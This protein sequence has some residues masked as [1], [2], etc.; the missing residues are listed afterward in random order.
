MMQ[1]VQPDGTI[2][3]FTAAIFPSN[4]SGQK[5]QRQQRNLMPKFGAV[6]APLWR[7]LFTTLDWIV[8]ASSPIIPVGSVTVQ[9]TW[10]WL[11]DCAE[12]SAQLFGAERIYVVERFAQ[13]WAILIIKNRIPYVLSP[14]AAETMLVEGEV[15]TTS[16]K[17]EQFQVPAN[18]NDNLVVDVTTLE[19]QHSEDIAAKE[20][21]EIGEQTYGWLYPTV[22]GIRPPSV[23]PF[24]E[25]FGFSLLVQNGDPFWYRPD[26]G[27]RSQL[28]MS[29]A[30]IPDTD[31]LN[32][33]REIAPQGLTVVSERL[34]ILHNPGGSYRAIGLLNDN[35]GRSA[36]PA[37][38][39]V[40]PVS[41]EI[42]ANELKH[43]LTG[44]L[45]EPEIMLRLSQARF[46]R[47][48]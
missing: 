5:F 11:D 34:L 13:I 2:R 16:I 23:N 38:V 30:Q 3:H 14:K 32:Y 17:I 7:R 26:L 31:A 19:I 15:H 25:A 12:S 24:A 41:Y 8:P 43:W 37:V 33:M 35:G 6:P 27:P 1:S 44:R 22:V 45:S 39:D 20:A 42:P 18:Y 40:V 9:A 4:Q 28:T 21:Q 46:A 10:D 47:A 48:A 29:W 36:T